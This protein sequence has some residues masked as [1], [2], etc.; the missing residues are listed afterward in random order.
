LVDAQGLRAFVCKKTPE[1]T[2][3]HHALNELV[4]RAMVFAG[5]PVTKE[6][7]GLSQ[8]DGKWPDGLVPWEAGKPLTC[9][10]TS[11]VR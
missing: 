1:R 4:A 3:R 11:C 10:V 6:P 5:I 8:S 7:N 9:D 2:A